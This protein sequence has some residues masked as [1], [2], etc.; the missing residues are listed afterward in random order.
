MEI[1]SPGDKKC[2]GPC[3]RGPPVNGTG[4]VPYVPASGQG[5]SPIDR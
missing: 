5:S 4:P 2:G 1:D 3:G